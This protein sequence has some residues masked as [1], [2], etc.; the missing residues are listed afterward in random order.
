VTSANRTT[1]APTN[2]TIA[3]NSALEGAA[4]I[5]TR[6]ATAAIAREGI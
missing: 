6:N 4:A 2:T 5:A 3:V 1:N